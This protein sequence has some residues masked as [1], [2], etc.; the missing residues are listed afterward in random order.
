MGLSLIEFPSAWESDV[1]P[2]AVR[3]ARVAVWTAILAIVCFA[4]LPGC[5]KKAAAGAPPPP[6]VSVLSV[7]KQTIPAVYEWVAEAAAS[8]SVQVRAQVSGVIVERP[9]VEG[10]DV[11]KGKVLYRID[12]RTYQANYESAKARLAESEAQFANAERTL[13]RLKPLLDERAVAQ[14]DVDNA[15]AA[16]DQGRAA[17]LD[18]RAAVDAAKKNYDDTFVRSEI[19]GRAGRAIMEVGALTS[20][21]G[22]QLTTVDQVDPIYVYF[23]PSDQ[24]VL[25]W[26]RDVAAK[27]LILPKGV[28]DVQATLADGSIFGQTGKLNFIAATLQPNTSALQLRAEFPNPQHT[29]LPGQFVRVRVLGLKRNDAILVPQRAVQQGL[30]GPFVYTL[31]DSNKVSARPVTATDWQG[32]QWIIDEGLKPGDKVIVDG[33]QKIRP[34][35]PVRTVAYDPKSD[36]TLAERPDTTVI[37][38]PSAAPPIQVKPE[39]G[40]RR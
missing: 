24:F 16:Y 31:A 28:L 22:D 9:Y 20:G 38:P 17:V 13:N 37:A 21:S 5:R 14:Q 4:A 25:Q 7:Q 8:K 36:S 6:E 30:N 19:T 29:L 40:E 34:D 32:T 12:P 26:R 35:S 2:T 27:R 3:P 23:N 33:A 11:P 10:T 39:L 18:A 1:N 15:Q